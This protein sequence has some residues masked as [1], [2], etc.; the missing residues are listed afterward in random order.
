[1]KLV[2]DKIK[3]TMYAREHLRLVMNLDF[4]KPTEKMLE[5]AKKNNINCNDP[6]VIA[7]FKK[8]QQQN[9]LDI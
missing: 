4:T 5:M 1:M 6:A 8:I 9:L 3:E 2:R 7:E